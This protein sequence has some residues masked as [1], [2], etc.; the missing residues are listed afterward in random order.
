MI[1]HHSF[2]WSKVMSIWLYLNSMIHLLKWHHLSY[3]HCRT[4]LASMT[5][6]LNVFF[7]VFVENHL[8]FLAL[9]HVHYCSLCANS[10]WM[11]VMNNFLK[12]FQPCWVMMN[13][14]VC[15]LLKDNPDSISHH[16]VW[17]PVWY[18]QLLVSLCVK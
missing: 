17:C 15:N 9:C 12:Y 8:N 3:C 10:M 7:R 2:Y 13:G 11:Y 14:N 18:N 5:N 6:G 4:H 16:T 1:V